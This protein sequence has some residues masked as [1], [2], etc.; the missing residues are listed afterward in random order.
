MKIEITTRHG[1]VRLKKLGM[2]LLLLVGCQLPI[3]AQSPVL[4][5]TAPSPGSV[6]SPGQQL[7]VTVTAAQGATLGAVFVVAQ[8]LGSSTVLTSAPFVYSFDMPTSG[9]TGPLTLTAVGV[10]G[11]GTLV[12]STAVVISVERL[13]PPSTLTATPPKIAFAFAGQQLGLLISG[14][15]SDGTIA[16]LT[17]SPNILYK[18]GDTSVVQVG[19]DGTVT[20]VGAGSTQVTAYYGQLS[21]VVSTTVPKMVRGDLNGDGKVDQDDLDILLDALNQWATGPF[22]ARDLNGD[23]VI[24]ALDARILVTLCSRPGCATH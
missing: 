15:Y 8:N 2:T 6:V 19:V 7:N 14:V 24:N 12:F 16:D 17:H 1:W 20:A 5:I 21:I 13:M 3:M 22:D 11:L 23:G 4:Q 18:S 9:F 10:T